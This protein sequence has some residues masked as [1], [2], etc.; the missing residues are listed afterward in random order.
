MRGS[1]TTVV[2]FVSGFP[3]LSALSAHLLIV[4]K[5][6]IHHPIGAH[7]NSKGPTGTTALQSAARAG[8][9]DANA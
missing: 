5:Q 1:K 9:L 2:P 7:V 6:K 3:L 8:R 4:A